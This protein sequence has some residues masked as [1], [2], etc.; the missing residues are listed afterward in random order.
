MGRL[1]IRTCPVSLPRKPLRL[2]LDIEATPKTDLSLSGSLVHRHTKRL[3]GFRCTQS[4]PQCFSLSCA[5]WMLLLI[6]RRMYSVCIISRNH[7][8][9]PGLWLP[10][11]INTKVDQSVQLHACVC[12]VCLLITFLW[13]YFSP[14]SR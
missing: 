1:H 5:V 11:K 12:T 7:K 9:A 10:A 3:T 8:R 13:R 2:S 4:F 6:V 14:R